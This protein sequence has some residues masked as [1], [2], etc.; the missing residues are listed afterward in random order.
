[1]T[2]QGCRCHVS[3]KTE[4]ANADN[5]DDNDGFSDAEEQFYGTNLLVKDCASFICGK[6]KSWLYG[7]QQP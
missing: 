5:D 6:G 3:C 7:I 2:H 1:M 4:Q